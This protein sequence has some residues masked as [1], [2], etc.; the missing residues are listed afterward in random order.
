MKKLFYILSFLFALNIAGF[1]Q[2]DD[3]DGKIPQRMT[4]YIQKRLG[5]SRTEAERFSPVFLDYFKEVRRTHQQNK[6]D[7]LLLQQKVVDLR[8][9]YRDQFKSIIGDKRSNDVFIYEKA[10]IDEVRNLQQERLKGGDLRPNK[11]KGQLQ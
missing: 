1:A 10:F 9:R 2:E 5:L 7:R 6:G 8:I 3:G 11:R 4:E